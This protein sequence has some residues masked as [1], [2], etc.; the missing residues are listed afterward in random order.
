MAGICTR[1]GHGAFEGKQC[2]ECCLHKT[3][4]VI[5]DKLRCGE[6]GR[7]MAGMFKAGHLENIINSTIVLRSKKG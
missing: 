4:F 6:C 3:Q 1:K 7:H 2:P 5:T